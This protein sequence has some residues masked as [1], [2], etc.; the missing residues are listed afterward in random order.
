VVLNRGGRELPF[1]LRLN[2][3]VCR[4]SAPAGSIH[5]VLIGA[6]ERA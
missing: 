4:L 5:T 6:A 3:R 2:D 1:A